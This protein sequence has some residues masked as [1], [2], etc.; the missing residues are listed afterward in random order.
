LNQQIGVLQASIPKFRN[1]AEKVKQSGNCPH[2]LSTHLGLVVFDKPESL[3][4]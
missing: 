3:E 2:S 1:T 4:E